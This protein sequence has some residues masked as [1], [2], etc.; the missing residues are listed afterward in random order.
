MNKKPIALIT[1]GNGTIGKNIAAKLCKDYNLILVGQKDFQPDHKVLDSTLEVYII[2]LSVEK[3]AKDLIDRLTEDSY[4]IELLVHCAGAMYK[5]LTINEDGYE[6]TLALQ[7]RNKYLLTL[8]LA[9]SSCG[10]SIKQNVFIASGG[11]GAGKIK[12]SNLKE[13]QGYYHGVLGIVKASY[14]SDVAHL[15][16]IKKLPKVVHYNYGPGIVKSGLSSNMSKPFR[17]IL[18][19]VSSLFGTPPQIVASE[20][21]KLLRSNKPSGYYF[22]G[23]YDNTRWVKKRIK[24]DEIKKFEEVMNLN[25]R[26]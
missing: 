19:I 5:N 2:D 20:V 24:Y 18:R 17:T 1:G 21:Y 11:L 23:K 22:R 7:V 13:W 16:L 25:T 9:E 15:S 12:M 14:L 26:D 10:Q 6:S 8:W 3:G 4:Q